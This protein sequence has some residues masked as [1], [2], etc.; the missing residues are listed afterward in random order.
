[1]DCPKCGHQQADTIKCASCG[2]YFAKFAQQQALIASRADAPPDELPESGFGW[3]ALALTAIVSTAL[4]WYV[5]RGHATSPATPALPASAASGAAQSAAAPAPSAAGSLPQALRGL[6]AQLA[7]NF[8]ARNAIETARNATVFI[9]TGWG[10]GSG[11][12]IDADCHVVTNR[13]VVETDGARVANMAVSSTEMRTRIAIA[14]QQLRANIIQQLQLRR[15]LAGQP[16]TNLQVIEIDDR[17]QAMK[18]EL[19]DLPARVN[20]AISDKV[21]GSGRSG[22]TAIVVDGTEFSSLHAQYADNR[23]LAIFQL[24]AEHCPHLEPGNSGTLAQGERLYTI[25][26]PSGLAYSVTSGIFSGNRGAGQERFLQTDAPIN[27]GNS[28]G[29]LIRENGEV[30][31]I[32]TLVLQ[33]AQ[34]IGFAIPIEAVYQEFLQLRVPQH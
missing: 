29:P 24:P 26:N 28:G 13:H 23:D 7:R 16:G 2:I 19:A 21:E 9:K 31:G 34:G 15:A 1:M 27:P 25:G 5:L 4:A 3:R 8:P 10:M 20:H 12:I 18:E 22:F 17:I 32:N 6:E 33:G 30:V 11:F 14:E